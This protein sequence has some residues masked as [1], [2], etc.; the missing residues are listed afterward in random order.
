MRLLRKRTRDSYYNHIS[1]D[2]IRSIVG[3][4]V[5]KM[6]FKFCFERN[7]WDRVLSFY[8]WQTRR[9]VRRPTLLE[10]LK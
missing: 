7:P 4:R 3:A 1:A 6:Y 5:W 2:E 8:F 10:F 9:R